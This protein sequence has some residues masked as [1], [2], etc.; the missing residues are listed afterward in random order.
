MANKKEEISD[1]ITDEAYDDPNFKKGL[2]LKFAQAT[3]KLTKVDR[4]NK[5]TYGEHIVLVGGN[6]AST[7][8]GHNIIPTGPGDLP[9]CKDC[10]VNINEPSTEDGEKKALDRQDRLNA[11]QN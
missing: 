3:I 11:K 4:K 10:K 7:H 8:D 1:M 2:V 6:V 9:Y 5:R